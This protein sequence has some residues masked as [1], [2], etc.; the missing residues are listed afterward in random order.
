MN[1][2]TVAQSRGAYGRNEGMIIMASCVEE[3]VERY[4]ALEGTS[5]P[6]VYVVRPNGTGDD[7]NHGDWNE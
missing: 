1:A 7:Y 4:I 3:A 5:G 6:C 2:Y